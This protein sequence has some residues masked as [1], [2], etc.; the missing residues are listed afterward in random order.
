[1][2]ERPTQAQAGSGVPEIDFNALWD[3]AF[4]PPFSR[5]AMPENTQGR[6][7][8]LN[9]ASPVLQLLDLIHRTLRKSAKSTPKLR[10]LV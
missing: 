8:T 1:M 3:L 4:A 2:E 9:S 5:S 10:K 7:Y 6:H